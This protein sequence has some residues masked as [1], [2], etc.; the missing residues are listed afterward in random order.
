MGYDLELCKMCL[1]AFDNDINKAINFFLENKNDL[2]DNEIIKSKLE[3][4]VSKASSIQESDKQ[5]KLEKAYKAN[6]LLNTIAK[7]MPEDDE[8]YL[9]LNI[10]E[11]AFYINKYYSLL[12]I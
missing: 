10:D 12:D 4:M 1:Q 7:D 2:L 11:D 9:D 3:S 5:N 6:R 8:A